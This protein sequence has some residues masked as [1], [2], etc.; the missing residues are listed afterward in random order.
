[1]SLQAVKEIDAATQGA[2]EREAFRLMR[3]ADLPVYR[4]IYD[5][6][7]AAEGIASVMEKRAPNWT[8]H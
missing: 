3:E 5:S 6:D 4:R 2:S 7:D 8:G 1:M